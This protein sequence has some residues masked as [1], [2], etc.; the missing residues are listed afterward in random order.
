MGAHAYTSGAR[1]AFA[2]GRYDP[3]SHGGRQLL[4]HEL[5]HV[6]QQ[7][8]GTPSEVA[9]TSDTA[10][11]SQADAAARAVAA[12][13]R[14]PAVTGRARFGAI[15]MAPAAPAW[16]GATATLDRSKVEIGEVS[17]VSASVAG[18]VVALVPASITVPVVM[19][20]PAVK[21]LSWE[22]YDPA[23]AF[24]NGG[25]TSSKESDA[26][27]RPYKLEGSLFS[28]KVS[29]GRYTLRCVGRA[30]GKPV[31]YADR[32]FYVWTSAPT[33]MKD[34][35]SLRAITAAPAG[36]SL[37]VVGAAQARTMMLEHREAVAATGTG[38]YMG[39]NLTTAAPKGVAKEDCTTY[40]LK[41]LE[42]AFTAKG[43]KS[44][45]EAVF[46]EAQKTS[47]GKFKGTELLK[48]LQSKAGWKAV[49]WAPDPRNPEDKK[50]EHPDA[51]KKVKAAGT[52]YGIPVEKDKS[53]VEYRRTSAT[54]AE[55]WGNIDR[56]RRVPL[57]VIAARG[58]DHMTLLLNGEVYEVHW[59]LPATD[60]NV[61]EATP[62][63]KWIWQSGVVVMPAADY[64]AAFA[65]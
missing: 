16:S 57:G 29:E 32:T 65:P 53:A 64:K 27:T 31:V 39:A 2:P 56:L 35:A 3:G 4:A 40:V 37:G 1:V 45:W 59:D 43:I 10:L 47:A 36:H 9:A 24:V 42:G 21:H 6:V 30:N 12:G 17:N 26:T 18:G 11:E 48:A 49:F 50:P 23:D 63:E 15:Q 19:H 33:S 41:V 22:L 62:L 52:Y 44:D 51:Y 60:P 5:T 34:L 58:G 8:A 7:R 20:D 28:G 46:K 55:S 38:K 25:S 61:I 54:A 14:A 13:K